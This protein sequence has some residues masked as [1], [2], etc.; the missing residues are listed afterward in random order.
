MRCGAGSCQRLTLPFATKDEVT[1][2]NRNNKAKK[3]DVYWVENR[4]LENSAIK[5]D[6][7]SSGNLH[8]VVVVGKRFGKAKIR[9]M[10]SKTDRYDNRGVIYKP[11]SDVRLNREGVIVTI[12][13]SHH[14]VP[15]KSLQSDK[16]LGNVGRKVLK[17]IRKSERKEVYG[18]LSGSPFRRLFWKVVILAL[19]AIAAY[20]VYTVVGLPTS[21]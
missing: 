14:R 7:A 13:D 8:P 10:T 18:D 17:Q 12:P 6:D 2:M 1:L 16:Y 5:F 21:L 4:L 11:T 9:V 15:V 19:L 20:F 3:G